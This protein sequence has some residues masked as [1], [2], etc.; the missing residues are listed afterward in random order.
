M[1]KY[2]LMA[3][4]ALV[5]VALIGCKDKKSE[6]TEDPG[7]QTEQTVKV[8]L[9]QSELELAIGGEATLFATLSP[10]KNLEITWT[11]SDAKIA[12]V[13]AEGVVTGVAEGTAT[14][15]ASAEGATA[16]TCTVTVVD[17]LTQFAWAGCEIWGLVKDES[18]QPVILNPEK[19]FIHLNNGDSVACVIAQAFAFLWSEGI[20]ENDEG[21]LEG[22]GYLAQLYIPVPVIAA[23][24]GPYAQYNGQFIGN[25]GMIEIIDATTYTDDSLFMA[26]SAKLVDAAQQYAYINGTSTE[27]GITGSYVTYIDLDSEDGD[28]YP[29]DALLGKGLYLQD[30][31]ELYYVSNVGWSDGLFG[32]AVKPDYSGFVEPYQFANFKGY[33]Y[34]NIPSESAAPAAKAPAR[35][36]A[37][38]T[39]KAVSNK[40]TMHTNTIKAV[41]QEARVKPAFTIA[42]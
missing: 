19:L 14:I 21:R 7:Q 42:K 10:A 13:D 17:P 11:T 15:T 24:S 32:L 28:Y 39:G 33:Q 16:A 31:D 6:E 25:G 5:T 40:A 3:T 2:F 8:V 35:R 38:Q 22:T 27:P 36:P 34:R 1:K 20:A 4:L 30:E 9:S 41:A 18:K 12:T 26:P 29:Y 37:A 23:E